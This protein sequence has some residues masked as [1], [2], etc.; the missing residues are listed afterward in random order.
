LKKRNESNHSLFSFVWILRKLK[1]VKREAKIMATRP[2]NPT[3]VG[4][5]EEASNCSHG[6]TIVDNHDRF[7]AVQGSIEIQAAP[8]YQI[9]EVDDRREG[10]QASLKALEL[11]WSEPQH[12]RLIDAKMVRFCLSYATTTAL[13]EQLQLSTR[14]AFLS[15]YLATWFKLGKET[16]LQT[17]R[18]MPMPVATMSD[19]QTSM[20]KIG[21]ERGLVLFLSKQIPCSCLDEVEKDAKQAPKTGRCSNCSSE[22]LKLELKKCSQCK[23]VQYCSKEC[24]VVDWRYVHKK[25]CEYK[26]QKHE[27]Q[28]AFK[29]AQTRR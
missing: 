27:Q 1:G 6:S 4:Q 21:T 16:F 17:F 5:E 15:I 13:G 19:F 18:G 7:A 11:F 2:T 9:S 24:Q 22:G 23:S 10:M 3:P 28:V 12:A 14:L 8:E 26:K 25:E 20:A 29:A